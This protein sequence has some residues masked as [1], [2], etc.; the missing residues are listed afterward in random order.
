LKQTGRLETACG[1][2]HAALDLFRADSQLNDYGHARAE[3]AEAVKGLT[4]AD[5]SKVR[6]FLND[7]RS[8]SFLD[9]MQRRLELAEPEEG[10]R[11]A[12]AWR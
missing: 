4:G 6:N 10:Q 2:A 8:L 7:P 11:E 3:I 5:W 9:R 12:M 1:R